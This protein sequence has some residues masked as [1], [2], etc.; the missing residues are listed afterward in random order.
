[1]TGRRNSEWLTLKWGHINFNTDPI[2]YTFV[3]KGAKASK[4][5]LPDSVLEAII[6]YLQLRYGEDF[7]NKLY[8]DSYLFTALPGKGGK[9]QQEDPNNPLT[10]WSMLRIV[11]SLA[12]KAGID[13]STITVHSLRHLHTESYLELG[14]SVEDI[15][16]RLKH[17]SLATT[18]TYVSSMGDEKNPL[19]NQLDN[20][21]NLG[22]EENSDE[23]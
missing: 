20:L 17:Q 18:Q 3:R 5:E 4:D 14:A 1:M 12:V 7:K 13:K 19:A 15:R 16:S 23:S 11:Q 2:T 8:K 6:H 21:I 10:L 9:R 22:G